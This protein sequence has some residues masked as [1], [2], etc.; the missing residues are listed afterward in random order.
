MMKCHHCGE[1][2]TTEKRVKLPGVKETCLACSAYL[3][4]CKNCAFHDPAKN[5]QC[6]VPNAD[7]VPDK[8]GA[9]FCGHF[10]FAD[11]ATALPG[12]T[13][14]DASRNALDSLFGDS[15]EPSDSSL[16]DKFKGL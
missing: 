8:E 12:S 9:N 4:C 14:D 11:T 3:H 16:L 7:W 6:T 5:N 13:K 15:D 2:W 10:K 1:E